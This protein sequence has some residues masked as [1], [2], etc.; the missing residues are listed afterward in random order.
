MNI[1]RSALCGNDSSYSSGGRK[2]C[3][4]YVRW[5]GFSLRA[6]IVCI[7]TRICTC[8]CIHIY[9]RVCVRTCSRER[10]HFSPGK[11]HRPGRTASRGW[12][13]PLC[14]TRCRSEVTPTQ[15]NPLSLPP[16]LPPV[17]PSH[18][19]E[20]QNHS[21]SQTGRCPRG[22]RFAPD[23]GC[24]TGAQQWGLPYARGYRGGF[25]G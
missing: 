13:C 23:G 11:S 2:C 14:R 16:H 22:Q 20:S 9:V 5:Y 8:V 18:K 21:V 10:E 3:I 24:A 4:H 17:F 12:R 1:Q 15:N 25:Q 19:K 7:N 6:N